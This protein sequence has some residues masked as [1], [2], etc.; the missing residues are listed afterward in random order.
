MDDS[1]PEVM[2]ALNS[3]GIVGYANPKAVAMLRNTS[4][5]SGAVCK[6]KYGAK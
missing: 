5:D 6:K 3:E 4:C 1:G 2:L